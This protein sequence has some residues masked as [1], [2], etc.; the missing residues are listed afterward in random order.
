MM[1]DSYS[2]VD[3]ATLDTVAGVA[4]CELQML[5]QN[6][7]WNLLRFIPHLIA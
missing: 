2:I 6:L 7:Y 1:E 3:A 5:P 4:L